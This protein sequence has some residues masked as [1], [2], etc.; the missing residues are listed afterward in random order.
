M[1]HNGQPLPFVSVIVTVRNGE[2][3]IGGCLASLLRTD[4]PAD[5]REILVADFGS[6]DRTAEMV[7]GFPVRYLP[8]SGPG[9]CHAR[10]RGIEASRGELLAFTDPDCIV[11][12]RWLR[13]LVG[14]FQREEVGAVGGGILP[15]PGSTAAERFA[16]RRRSHSQERPLSH[17]RR[18]FVLTP[19]VAFRREVFERIG[20]FDTA[21]PGGGWEDADLCWRLTRETGL[22]LAYAPNAAVF[23][24]YRTTAAAFFVQHLRYGYGLGLLRRKYR[25]ELSLTLSDRR[26]SLRELGGAALELAA[27][28]LP[29]ADGP[30]RR[31]RLETAYFALLRQLGQKVGGLRAAFHLPRAPR[32]AP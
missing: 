10:N 28:L 20:R 12:S 31:A 11:S 19:N 18:P 1:S 8:S 26:R 30:A 4:Y 23:H 25:D 3:E 17:P 14:P 6:T 16:A 2:D 21:F 13:D 29:R 24:R 5:R 15:Y 22:E 27:A 9:V 7:R 32:A